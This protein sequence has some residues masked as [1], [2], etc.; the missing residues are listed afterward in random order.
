MSALEEI[1][2][3]K[4]CPWS[5]QYGRARFIIT[6]QNMRRCH[7]PEGVSLASRPITGKR[8]QVRNQRLYKKSRHITARWPESNLIEVQKYKLMC[9]LEGAIDYPIGSYSLRCGPGHFIFF[10]PGLP[11]F[12]GQT[13]YVDSTR[14]TFCE[15]LF[16]LLHPN[17]IQYWINNWNGGRREYRENAVILNQRLIT[18]FRTLMEEIF[19][20]QHS[21]SL[22]QETLLTAFLSLAQREVSVGSVSFMKEN[23]PEIITAIPELDSASGFR[24][25]LEQYIR[26]NIKNSI[27]IE[28]AARALYLSRAQFTRTVRRETG[29]SFNEFLNVYRIEEAK[30]LLHNSE[31]TIVFIAE[32]LGFSSADYFRTF[33]RKHTGKTPSEFRGEKSI[34]NIR[35]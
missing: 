18:L 29:M 35:T 6:R 4:L 1:I 10:P 23:S 27:S 20:P 12:E 16:F 14:S 32:S 34:R 25:E 9:V 8:F 3:T 26:L 13:S 11:H 17:A 15:T 22:A 28:N 33:F 31:W 21:V 7:L 5:T 19:E 2:R 24:A 30:V